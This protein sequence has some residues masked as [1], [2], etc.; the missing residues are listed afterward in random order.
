MKPM[1]FI[2]VW[3][4]HGNARVM[5]DIWCHGII[6]VK[7]GLMGEN[8]AFYLSLRLAVFV[9]GMLD[10]DCQMATVACVVIRV[11]TTLLK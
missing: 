6:L 1:V 5:I 8:T 7:R 10:I 9:F 11:H 4:T 2:S 3:I